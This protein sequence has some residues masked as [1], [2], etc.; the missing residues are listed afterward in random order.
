MN[1]KQIFQ[2][3]GQGQHAGNNTNQYSL[4]WVMPEIKRA[5]L[6][7]TNTAESQAFTACDAATSV[8]TKSDE[9]R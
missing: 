1:S 2:G 5:T 3:K 4:T 9:F 6:V 8:L 7:I